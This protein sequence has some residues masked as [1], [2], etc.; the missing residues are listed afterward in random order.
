[1]TKTA[2]E[3]QMLREYQ[4][5]AAKLDADERRVQEINE[6]IRELRMEEPNTDE[7]KRLLEER[8]NLEKGITKADR[9]L[10]QMEG[11]KP[12]Q[13]IAKIQRKEAEE[14]LAKAKR[15]LER[16]KEGVVQREYIARI[17]TTSDRLSKWLTKP[18]NQRYVPE[19]MRKPLAEF[20]LAI[21]RGS[22]TM[23]TSGGMTKAD[24]DYARVVADL[25]DVISN[26]SA[27]QNDQSESDKVFNMHI[28]LPRGFA[29]LM[30]EHAKK[31]E[32]RSAEMGGRM[33][34][35]RMNT[36]EL[37]ELFKTLTAISSTITHTNDFL[38]VEN[39]KHVS[40]V[41]QETIEYL[42]EQRAVKTESKLGEF[43]NW[44]NV[45]PIYAFE[46]Y[47]NGGKR[48]FKML[49]NGQS[50]LAMNTN[51]IVKLSKELYTA[52]EAKQWSEEI[53]TFEIGGKEVQIPV[54]NIMSLY[55]LMRRQQGIGHLYGEGIR[56]GDFKI[57]GK[58]MRDTGHNV[59]DADIARMIGSLTERQKDVAEKLQSVMST[60]GSRWGNEISMKRFGYRMFT[61][62]NY[63]PIEVDKTHLPARTDNGRGNELY[64]LL[65]ISSTKPITRGAN[66]R[67]MLNNIFD[68]YSSHMSDMA[69]YNAMALPV[70][71]AVKWLNYKESELEELG[72]GEVKEYRQKYT[73]SVRD[74]AR[75]AYGYA[76]NKYIIGVL[77]DIN[78]AQMTGGEA[79]GKMMLGRVNRA[80]VAANLRVA[81]LQ[82]LSI[83]RAGM[84]IDTSNIMKGMGIGATRIKQNLKEMEEHSGIA[85]WKNLGFYDVNI[86]RSV[87]KLIK[88][89]DTKM[90]KLIDAS[91]KGA[92]WA[93]RLTWS[94]MWEAAKQ[95]VAKTVD[96]GSD[97][98]MDKVSE[99]FEEVIYKT[100]V[101][102]SVLTRSQ[103]MRNTGFFAKWTSSFMS[104]PTTTYN[105][106]L[107]AYNKFATEARNGNFQ[108]AWQKQG[109]MVLRTM[110]VYT[111]AAAMNAVV[112]SLMGAWRDDD[113]YE[114]FLEKFE[115]GM[116]DNFVNNMMPFNKLPLVSDLYENG[117]KYLAIFGVDTYGYSD[118][119]VITQW[120]DQ[121]GAGLQII[122]DKVS[123]K[124]TNYT[125][126]GAM[127]KLMQG[128]SSVTGVPIASFMRE[129][130]A[131]WNNTVGYM[132]GN[133]IQ[134]YK[135][136][137]SAGYQQMYNAIQAGNE[138]RAEEIRTELKE[139]GADDK[140]IAS[141]LRSLA[142][143]DYLNNDL[144]DEEAEE[145]LTKYCSMD[146]D[147]AFWQL[148]EWRWTAENDS[149]NYSVYAELEEAVLTGEGVE[150]A[151]SKLEEHGYEDK[152]ESKVREIVKEGYLTGE[153]TKTKTAEA[154]KKYGGLDDNEVYFKQQQYEYERLTGDSTSSDA[155][156]IF[157]SIDLEQS[158]QEAIDAA[159]AHGKTKSG[160]ASSLTSRYK[161]Q[162]LE[163]LKTNSSA[164]YKL[165]TRLAGIFDYLGYKG[166]EKVKGWE[167]SK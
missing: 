1:M 106:L 10:F 161:T 75:D 86:G 77:R 136:S 139:N 138:Q 150:E 52:K 142:K 112:E 26:I 128:F 65:N 44:D 14:S 45:Q 145:F 121:I 66:N 19:A 2:E 11:L 119:N 149:T 94:L 105:M 32:A 144:T 64:R 156:M 152:V 30:T 155:C 23:L 98:Y 55:C 49:Q 130:V 71:D 38:S 58:M 143:T 97:G 79:Y 43:L 153:L 147:K 122:A 160:L 102:D 5:I 29:E 22:E 12:L 37:E 51:E 67:I 62:Q 46:R 99:R 140:G 33:T 129:V 17:K 40:E 165:G 28:D 92:E 134:V 60:V 74:A 100:Q 72:L 42:R 13:R 70:L 91:M 25:R 108:Q 103:Y 162:Y 131:M 118:A 20:L 127:Y 166:T 132:T 35:N 7:E 4:D 110:S 76:A 164:A 61:E 126:Y 89:D 154:L 109:K 57:K 82:P 63:F 69:Q 104:E 59:G 135:T 146:E 39:A 83:V 93:D 34:L 48:V 8:R 3:A 111:V 53:K 68:V 21:D 31:I 125:G 133:K 114:T 96:P 73:E 148:E 123:G 95:D 6:R 47:G 115:D 117:K 56:V 101:V 80:A 88:H 113:D 116:L 120:L 163:L 36:Q 18:N 78:G 159:L 50:K 16:Y 84:V 167:T 87:S 137:K 90:D 85:A 41:S 15:H 27:Y 81:F 107:N 157:Y 54:A 141:G 124:P 151:V 24:R 158:P 9:R